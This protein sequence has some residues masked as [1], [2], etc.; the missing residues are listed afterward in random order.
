MKR[1]SLFSLFIFYVTLLFSQYSQTI[2]GVILD[3]T[4]QTPVFAA[5]IAVITTDPQRGTTSDIDGSFRIENVQ[6]GRH[7]IQFSCLGYKPATASVILTSGHETVLEIELTEMVYQADEVVI[8]A[9]QRKDK[10]INQMAQISAR[11]FTVEET[12]RY[13]GSWG[14]PARMASNFAGVRASSEARN[15]IVIRGN[16]PLGLLWRLEGVNVPNPN[17]FGVLGT[18][19]GP[20]SMLNNN[21]LRNSDFFTGAFPAEYGNALSGA[22]DLNM[23]SGNNQQHEYILQ[24]GLNGFEVGAEGPFSKNHSASYLVNYRY[25]F[26]GLMQKLGINYGPEGTVPEYQDLSFKLDLPTKKAGKFSLFGIAGNSNVKTYDSKK[27]DTTE[28]AGVDFGADFSFYSGMMTSGLTHNIALSPNTRIISRL[29]V[30]GSYSDYK[31]DSVSI[32]DRSITLYARTK[33]KEWQYELSTEIR[34]RINTK[35]NINFG[36]KAD[37]FQ[38]TYRDS[39]LQGDG[40]Y[41]VG[42]KADGTMTLYQGFGEWQHRLNDYFTL[43]GGVHAQYFGLN[44]SFSAEPRAS[45]RWNFLK[46]QSISLGYGLHSQ[47]Q[48]H[49]LYFSESY[50]DRT[51]E[52]YETT[53]KNLDFTKSHHIVLGYDFL[54]SK[55]LRFKFETYYQYIFNAPIEQISSY[56]SM[57]NYG[58]DF[59]IPEYDSLVNKGTGRNY[60]VEFT[61]EKFFSNNYYFLITTSLFEAKY[62][63]SDG[64][65]RNSA[66]NNNYVINLLGGY[67]FK[68]GK[69][70]FLTAST[71]F[72]TAGGNR[73]VPY[74]VEQDNNGRYTPEYDYSRAYEEQ[75][76]DYLRLDIMLTL[77]LNQKRVANEWIIDFENLTNKK[78]LYY[79]SV[80]P[81][82]GE[83]D[84]TYHQGFA[85]LMMWR[86]RF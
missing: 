1:I 64:I 46:G 50:N 49:Q 16:S 42:T 20:I 34:S 62:K 23:R 77:R 51:G 17:H 70:T 2:R 66:F 28:F 48:P 68:L 31:Y 9:N 57:L 38:P 76:P 86:M 6:I 69:N 19:G 27:E 14:D 13:A 58:S 67:E 85:W 7:E 39:T 52:Y 63:G 32:S 25:S 37:V 33:L 47:L 4:T 22:F 30:S 73:Y 54:I 56:V 40:T 72:V 35:N 60:G 3:A 65:E 15:D 74:T 80:N 36:I 10:P 12:E 29:S 21:L 81:V 78:N 61:L 59:Y 18:T 43:Y 55:N 11:S 5:N 82:T 71:K 83:E 75:Y 53:N 41:R 45:I 79:N 44:G 84:P 26:L 24:I 8:T